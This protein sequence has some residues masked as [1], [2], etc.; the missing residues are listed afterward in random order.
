M[1]QP[2][3]HVASAIQSLISAGSHSV[4]TF[5]GPKEV[6]K[7]TRRTYGQRK[8]KPSDPLDFVVTIGRPAWL[9]K[10]YGKRAAKEGRK[11]PFNLHRPYPK[12]R[13]KD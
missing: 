12:K 5:I 2:Y 4:I 7:V 10:E 3:G 8:P 11:F 13:N 6:I 9:E 1:S